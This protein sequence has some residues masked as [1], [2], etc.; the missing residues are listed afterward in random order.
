MHACISN[1]DAW[2]VTQSP[3][4]FITSMLHINYKCMSY[5][6]IY[7]ILY[8]IL[9]LLNYIYCISKIHVILLLLACMHISLRCN[10]CRCSPDDFVSHIHVHEV[11]VHAVQ[12]VIQMV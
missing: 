10:V 8:Y 11:H 1:K 6:I 4:Y 9:L 12:C 7:I 2:H 5:I 3:Q